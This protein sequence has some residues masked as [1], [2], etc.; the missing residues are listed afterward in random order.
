[1]GHLTEEQRY[2]IEVMRKQGCRQNF[3]A[4]AI[5]KNKSVVSRELKRN[6]DKRNDEYRSELATRKYKDRLKKK[7]K[8]KK[9]TK[10]LKEYIEGKLR[11]R[12]SPE[13]ISKTVCPLNIEMVSHERIYQH[14]I[15]NK[16]AGGD[17]YKC[18]RRKKKYR[19]RLAKDSRG[20]INNQKNISERPAIVEEKSRTG[21]L[22]I[23]LIIGADHQEAILTANCR[24]S[25]KNWMKKLPDKKAITVA[26]ALNKLLMP[27][28]NQIHTITS[29]NGKEFAEHEMVSKELG[30]KYY[31]ADPYSSWQRGSNENFNGLVRDY[32][33]K[34]TK[35]AT[36]TDAEVKKVSE[37]LNQ[38]P[39]KR[40]GF[41][42]PSEVF[43]FLTEK[44]AFKT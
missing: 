7:A 43:N 44:V 36:I 4:S 10:E 41:Q 5:G 9:L 28:K 29:D 20:K 2:T 12:W 35:F 31:F 18:L 1:M 30:I 32:F 26:V 17:L 39:R 25:G 13:Q 22:E 33:P 34:K 11:L 8:Q 15:A 37:A 38:R 42:T 21:D 6:S 23:D 3:I 16:K 27:F 40:L 24:V 14:I 19:K